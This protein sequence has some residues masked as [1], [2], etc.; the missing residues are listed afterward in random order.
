VLIDSGATFQSA[1]QIHEAAKKVTT[2]PISGSSTPAGRTT[3]GWATATSSP[4][5]IETIA[6]ADGEADMK[7]R[8]GD[9]LEGL[10]AT[11]KEQGRR[12]R[13]HAAHALA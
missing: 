6:H 11:L 8:G 2:Q 1:R 13:A 7:A 9:H 12:H 3:A 10:K 5:G 4:R